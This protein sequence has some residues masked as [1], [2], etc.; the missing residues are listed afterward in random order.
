[1]ILILEDNDDRV[2]RFREAAH[3]V[4]PG[5]AVRVWRSAP[6]MMRGLVDCLEHARLIS[7]DHDLIESPGV[8]TD[9]GTGYDVVKFLCELIPV[10]PLV[11]HTSNAERGNWMIGELSRSGWAYERVYPFGDRWIADDWSRA[12]GKCLGASGE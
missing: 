3:S 9:A 12:V 4:A 7:L 5:E 1:M 6:E 10:C 11:I 8:T 2:R